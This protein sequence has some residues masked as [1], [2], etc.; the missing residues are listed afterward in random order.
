M[1][2]L[3]NKGISQVVAI[4]LIVGMTLVALSL[5]GTFLFDLF[6]KTETQLAPVVSCLTLQSK[7][8]SA[9]SSDGNLELEVLREISDDE[10]S[11]FKFLI[12][13]SGKR[14]SIYCGKDCG[15]CN[16]QG[17]G[18]T[19]KFYFNSEYVPGEITLFA[20]EKCNLGTK[21][22]VAC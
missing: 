14:E 13:S 10:I 17:I 22:V 7:I 3:N 4:I 5:L 16:I 9:C 1:Q 15:S 6:E 8:V 18:Q 12:E 21:K 19:K 2:G 11:S 20:N